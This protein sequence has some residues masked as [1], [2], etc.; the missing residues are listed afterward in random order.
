MEDDTEVTQSQRQ[1]G[2][3]TGSGSVPEGGDGRNGRHGAW[4]PQHLTVADRVELRSE[5]T[6][7]LHHHSIQITSKNAEGAKHEAPSYGSIK[8]LKLRLS[9]GGVNQ[10]SA[11]LNFSCV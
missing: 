9:F 10:V 3:I 6:Q 5:L 11:L 1:D 2:P 4:H 8:N 7:Q